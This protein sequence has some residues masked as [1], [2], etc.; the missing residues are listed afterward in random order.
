MME[1]WSLFNF[2]FEY[3]IFFY[4]MSIL[5][6]YVVLLMLSMRYLRRYKKAKVYRYEQ[7]IFDSSPFTPGVSIVAPAY[8][9]EVTIINNVNSM[10]SLD[11]PKFEVVI[12]ND[13]SKDKT[14]QLLIDVF[15]MEEVPYAYIE[16]VPAKPFKR[17]FKSKNPKYYQLTVV[18]KQ[19]GGTKADASNA[20]VNVARYP[21]FVCTDVDCILD[22]DSLYNTMKEVTIS[23]IEVIAVSATMRMSN[24]CD[25][26]KGRIKAVKA[27]NSLIPLFQELEYLRSY[28][29]G[30]M[31]WSELNAMPNVSGGFGFFKRDVVINAGGYNPTSFAEDMECIFSIVQYMVSQEKP[32]KITQIPDTCC[33]TEG[34]SSVS[35]LH[36]QRRR[37]GRGFLQV[38]SINRH[39]MLNPQMKRLGVITSPYMMLFEA[40][41]PLIEVLGFI[42]LFIIIVFLD[43]INWENAAILM[44]MVFFF[45]QTMTLFCVYL[46]RYVKV[47]YK[48]RWE[49]LKLVLISPL[50]IVLY[51]PLILL[52]TIDG[53]LSF[54]SKKQFKWG[55]MT[56]KG[57]AS[58]NDAKP[59]GVE[60][61][62]KEDSPAGSLKNTDISK[63]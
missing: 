53:Q 54:F 27:P 3:L 32:Y 1:Y 5:I 41:A 17:L 4:M 11:Y 43:R 52:F 29:I 58:K 56:R 51:H 38:F 25:V 48:S 57:F 7:L 44:I 60:T 20:G 46:D 28:I 62:P 45:S 35:I 42:Y 6:S 61:K 8:N 15:E 59:G 16:A 18:D 19:N 31:G 22:R 55:E 37:W 30:K 12:V 26:E 39:I 23:N 49:Y 24:G 10:L 63:V 2:V 36:R 50:E 21:Y 9:E 47:L 34:P 33:W 14:L 13:G 40:M